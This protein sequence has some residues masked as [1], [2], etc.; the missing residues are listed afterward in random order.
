MSDGKTREGLQ[1]GESKLPTDQVYELHRAMG[2]SMLFMPKCKSKDNPSQHHTE[3]RE[4]EK[5]V[6]E[7]LMVKTD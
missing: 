7:E 4:Q 2:H 5:G 3:G 1:R 6:K